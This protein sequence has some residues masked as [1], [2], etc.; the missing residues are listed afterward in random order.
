MS[1]KRILVQIDP[2][3]HP[4]VFDSVVAIDSGV[5]Q[6][7]TH[8][9]V[10]AD[11][12]TGLVHGCIFTRA[13]KDLKSTAIFFGGSNVDQTEQ[14]VAKAKDS[15]FGPM[16]VSIMSDPNGCNTTAAAAVLSAGQHLAWKDSTVTILAA[17][18]PVGIRIA[19]ILVREIND[20][21]GSMT[22]R[23]CSRRLE[24]AK[25]VCEDVAKEIRDG[26]G[27]KLEPLEVPD[28]TVALSAIAGSDAVFAAGA[29]GIELLADGWQSH[30]PKVVVDVNAVPPAGVQ[31]V[32]A[33]DK[34]E[35]RGETVC[36]GAIG[37]G[38]LKMMIH[39]KCI[40]SLFESNDKVLEVHEVHQVGK[41][42]IG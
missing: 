10:S 23:V 15:F 21:G 29:A 33:M 40:E 39:R 16:R 8:G 6:L 37:V 38:G 20:S 36:Y 31:G 30:H 27:V 28:S 42:L 14:L 35:L 1:K 41:T 13:V 26:D 17:T 22:I 32:E 9:S 18:G 34:G 4:S 11:A 25:K 19:Q 24:R 2:D 7:L 12:V 5:E 3:A